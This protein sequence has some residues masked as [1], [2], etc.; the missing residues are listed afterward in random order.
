MPLSSVYILVSERRTDLNVTI[1]VWDQIAYLLKLCSLI[2]HKT[3]GKLIQPQRN[4]KY[5]FFNGKIKFM[6]LFKRKE[7]FSNATYSKST[8]QWQLSH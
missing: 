8:L 3:S 4:F 6:K 2:C 5:L 1:S 7:Y